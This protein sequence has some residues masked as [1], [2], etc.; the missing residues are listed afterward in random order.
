M[1]RWTTGDQVRR[2]IVVASFFIE[3]GCVV[4]ADIVLPV[5]QERLRE[6]LNGGERLVESA[7]S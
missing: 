1:K 2:W 4:L 6:M 7:A 3:I 5:L